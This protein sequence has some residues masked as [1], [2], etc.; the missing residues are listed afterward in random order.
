MLKT[1][2]LAEQLFPLMRERREYLHMHPEVSL[3]EYETSKL[4]QNELNRLGIPFRQIEGTLGVQADIAGQMPG[5]TIVLRADMD[6]LSITE[7]EDPPYKSQVEGVMHACGHDIHTSALLGAAEILMQ[8][9]DEIKGTVRLIFESGEE[10]GGTYQKMKAAG[11]FDG[12]DHCFGIHVWAEVPI[13]KVACMP[14]AIMA[15]TD[16]LNLKIT[17]QGAHGAEPHKG[18]DSGVAA[19]AVV[20][21]LQTILSRELDPHEIAVVT[22]GKITAGE[23]FN[24]IPK[25]AVLEGNLRYFNPERSDRYPEMINRIA[26]NTAAAFLAKSEMMLH[27][28]GTPPVIND[29]DKTAF[30][31]SVITK[32]FGDDVLYDIPAIMAGEDFGFYVNEIGGL[33]V[34]MGGGFTDRPVWPQHSGHFDVD[35][36][37]LTMA[38][39]L[40]AQ[41]AIDWLAANAD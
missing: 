3:K 33:F 27:V 19:A 39:A 31:Q 12:V 8:M 2:E 10:V 20:M 13:G 34:F 25:E 7:L 9:R 38:A 5:K 21:N 1:L 30:G 22:I 16:L 26:E 4:V 35:E 23:R 36:R 6:A 41:Y 28:I 40:H 15:G 37:S 17:G 11:A 29:P 32:L 14:G 18:I 24:A